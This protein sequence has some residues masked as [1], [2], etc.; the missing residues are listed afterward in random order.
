[1]SNN[2]ESTGRFGNLTNYIGIAFVVAAF[3]VSLVQIYT[4][5]EEEIGDADV[6]VRLAHWQLEAG[7][8]EG[9]Q[10]AIDEYEKLHPG[11]RI[12]QITVPDRAFRE[13]GNTQ[14]I[15]GTAPDIIELGMMPQDLVARYFHTL[16]DVLNE[17][18]PYNKG[19]ELESVPW[20][21]TFFD[22]LVYQYNMDLREYFGVGL[23]AFTIRIV[24]NKELFQEVLGTDEPPQTLEEYVEICAKIR[25]YAEKT[26][27]TLVPIAGARYNFP[28][29][30]MSYFAAC[31]ANMVDELDIDF[32]GAASRYEA[33][34]AFPERRWSL[35]DPRYRAAA[36]MCSQF[37]RTFQPGWMGVQREEIVFMFAQKQAAMIIAGSW[38]VGSFDKQ[39]DFPLGAFEI[40]LPSPD[41]PQFGKYVVGRQTE[42]LAGTGFAFGITKF[43]D[44]HDVCIDF[45]QFLTTAGINERMNKKFNWLPVITGAQP[46]DL[47]KPFVP[48]TKGFVSGPDMWFGDQLTSGGWA[49]AFG[50]QTK[51]RFD[52]KWWEFA[53]DKIDFDTFLQWW[54]PEYVKNAARDYYDYLTIAEHQIK[55]KETMIA[56]HLASLLH[57]NDPKERA[58]SLEK[59]R[60]LLGMNIQQEYSLRYCRELFR[61]TREIPTDE[62]LDLFKHFKED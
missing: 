34:R 60:A 31:T 28:F 24:Y 53:A 36:G 7:I 20:R 6:V 2:N 51:I 23:S 29:F 50:S 9:L 21:E 12:L 14:L 15:G 13:W 32:N 19:T 1:M 52:Q 22:G 43:T 48:D 59:Y 30:A 37:G 4:A 55:Q 40:P 61:Q 49:G 46:N 35:H 38:D 39:S 62:T 44:H 42:A 56:V 16:S 27:R 18:N 41:H 45:M 25:A 26:G 54:K 57:H 5:R 33:F 10:E 47:L 11:T 58:K 17:P 8:R 3:I